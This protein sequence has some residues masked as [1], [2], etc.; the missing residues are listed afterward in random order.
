M[1]EILPSTVKGISEEKVTAE[2]PQ[3]EI[4]GKIADTKDIDKKEIKAVEITSE[5]P[6]EQVAEIAPSNVILEKEVKEEFKNKKKKKRKKVAEVEI[7]PGQ[8]P[9]LRGLTIVGKIDLIAEEELR[10][11]KDKPPRTV[12]LDEDGEEIL[13][14]K[15][16]PL[17]FK[18]KI[19]AK[20][21]E[22]VV[23]VKERL[24]DKKKKRKRSIREMNF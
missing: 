8:A 7:E 11:K 24:P 5:K 18:K 20:G 16:K 10:A 21:K 19:K 15:S 17:K 9:K 2:A 23:V 22:K 6:S 13:G 1:P 14:L 4:K 3:I 12:E